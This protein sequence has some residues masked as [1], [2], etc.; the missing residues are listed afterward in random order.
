MVGPL[1]AARAWPSW[2]ALSPT[3]FWVY[4]TH[5]RGC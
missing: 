4:C 5:G 1:F 2:F 3:V